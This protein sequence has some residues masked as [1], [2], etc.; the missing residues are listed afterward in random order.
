MYRVWQINDYVNITLG[1]IDA[2]EHQEL[3]WKY[4]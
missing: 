3:S 4:R 1:K 2:S